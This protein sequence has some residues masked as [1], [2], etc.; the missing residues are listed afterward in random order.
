[1]GGD[2][3]GGV[4]GSADTYL[5]CRAI[6]TDPRSRTRA[7]VL[8][9]NPR[10]VLSGMRIAGQAAGA[11]KGFV[12]VDA[13]DRSVALALETA[14]ESAGLGFDVVVV[15]VAATAVLEDDSA[16][17]RALEGRQ[18]IPRVSVPPAAAPTLWD[19]P[20]AV[21]DAEAL[22]DLALGVPSTRPITVWVAGHASVVEAAETAT[23]REILR[24]VPGA[25]PD[26]DGV[27]AVRLGGLLGRFLAGPGLDAPVGRGSAWCPA[28]LEVM[29]L[30]ACGVAL[31]GEALRSLSAESC[32]ACVVC[33]EGIRQ[34]AD[35]L[36]GVAGPHAAAEAPELMRE[37]GAALEAGSICG[38]G[39]GAADVLRSGL[40][41]FAADFRAHFA[42][43]PCT[44]GQAGA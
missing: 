1:M 26:A 16:L 10:A 36:V 41:A 25:D 18:P 28:V 2:R 29:P 34:L 13:D 31:V 24:D 12:C 38:L 7:I 8:A 20:V 43:A 40:E 4:T 39:W 19:R 42:G 6:D 32:G 14:L 44:R 30:G 22:A 17:L 33:R 5:V 3:Q 27:K 15:P 35:M 9:R 23:V 37:L 11:T 21:F